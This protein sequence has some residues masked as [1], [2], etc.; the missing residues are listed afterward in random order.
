[1]FSDQHWV[2]ISVRMRIIFSFIFC[3]LGIQLKILPEQY[4]EIPL[5]NQ[6]IFFCLTPKHHHQSKN[7]P[8][9][10]CCF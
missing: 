6:V 7:V 3:L 4:N 8:S 10:T 5:K 9:V 1:M 2:L